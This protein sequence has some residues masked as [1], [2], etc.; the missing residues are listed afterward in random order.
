MNFYKNNIMRDYINGKYSSKQITTENYYSRSIVP[1]A[2]NG[3]KNV[4]DINTY[5]CQEAVEIFRTKR[6][7]EM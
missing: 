4:S 3:N 2:R 6:K 1:Y 7:T 5:T